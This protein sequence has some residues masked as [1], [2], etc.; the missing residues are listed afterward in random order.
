MQFSLRCNEEIWELTDHE[1]EVM[2]LAICWEITAKFY[3]V[4]IDHNG[5]WSLFTPKN[6]HV[7]DV[8]WTRGESIYSFNNPQNYIVSSCRGFNFLP[9]Y[10]SRAPHSTQRTLRSCTLSVWYLG[11]ECKSVAVW[12]TWYQQYRFELYLK[13]L[14]QEMGHQGSACRTYWRETGRTTQVK[15]TRMSTCRCAFRT[16]GTSHWSNR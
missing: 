6:C 4:S 14:L 9:H 12:F 5:F 16:V 15:S 1:K 13:L 7:T 11:Q 2:I 10:L 3:M 8:T